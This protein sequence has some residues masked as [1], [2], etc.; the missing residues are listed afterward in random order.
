M[1]HGIL[2]VLW[3]ISTSLLTFAQTPPPQL[4]RN[5]RV[6]DGEHVLEHRSVLI[7]NGK[8]K[9]VRGPGA[10]VP[11]AQVIEGTGRTLLP[12]LIDAHVHMP[13]NAEERVRPVPSITCASGTAAPGPRT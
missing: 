7:E 13:D 4:I 12:G 9:W 5:V 1:N 2:F 3:T 6:F 8:I 11:D 10:A